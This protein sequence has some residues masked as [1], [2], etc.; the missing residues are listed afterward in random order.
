MEVTNNSYTNYT[1]QSSITKIEEVKGVSFASMIG[2]EEEMVEET[3]GDYVAYMDKHGGFDLLSEENQAVFKEILKDDEVTIDEIDSLSYEEAKLFHKYALYPETLSEEEINNAPI[4]NMT[5]QIGSM[6]FTTQT[7]NDDTFNEALY[8]TVREVN[9]DNIRRD[10]TNEVSINLAQVH[11]GSDLMASYT[12]G[13]YTNTPNLW[14][15]DVEKMNINFDNFLADVLN[16]HEEV[17]DNPEMSSDTKERSQ[18][19]LDGYNI[20][21]KHYYDIKTEINE[22]A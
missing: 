9:D 16:F 17:I 3:I 18:E 7:T 12:N 20:I 8:R 2:T 1:Q 11:F 19:L 14:A 15:E 5:S 4:V 6:F 13:A 10:I 22:Y 21:L